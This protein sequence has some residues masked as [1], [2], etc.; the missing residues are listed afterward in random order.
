MDYRRAIYNMYPT[1]QFF[2]EHNRYDTLVWWENTPKPTDEEILAYYESVKDLWAKDEMKQQRNMLLVRCD[3]C[4]L[5]D[6]PN[7]D[8]WL[9]YRQL[10][11][12]LPEDWTIDTPYPT[13]PE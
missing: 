11:R 3:H 7:R 9:I 2:I 4:A 1:A 12:D 10:L 5:P 8:P 6:F 13:P